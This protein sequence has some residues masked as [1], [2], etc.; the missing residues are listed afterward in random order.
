MI[1]D[2]SPLRGNVGLKLPIKVNKARRL[3]TMAAC[4]E[5]IHIGASYRIGLIEVW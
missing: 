3:R 1:V 4:G 5:I 2:I